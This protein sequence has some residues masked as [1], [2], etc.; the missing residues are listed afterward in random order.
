MLLVSILKVKVADEIDKNICN[1]DGRL[2][3][4]LS[5]ADNAW[6]NYAN[7][8]HIVRVKHWAPTKQFSIA[9]HTNKQNIIVK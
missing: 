5:V 6:S 4:V 3:C 7:Y 2:C 9:Y 8:V 1:D